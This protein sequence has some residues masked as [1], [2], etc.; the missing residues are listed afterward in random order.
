MY[1]L[2]VYDLWNW[3]RLDCDELPLI[4]CRSC[5]NGAIG[6]PPIKSGTPVIV[7][8]FCRPVLYMIFYT[9][10]FKDINFTDVLLELLKLSN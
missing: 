5:V 4:M 8:A 3:T 2:S 1:D 7:A 6:A 9:A 10:P